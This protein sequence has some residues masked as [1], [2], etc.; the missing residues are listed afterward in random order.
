MM[1]KYINSNESFESLLHLIN[2]SVLPAKSDSD[3]M[4]GLQS[5]QGLIIDRSFVY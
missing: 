1:I 5:Y 3:V 4:F 2:S